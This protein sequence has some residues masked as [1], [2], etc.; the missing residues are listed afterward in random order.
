MDKKLLGK[1]PEGKD[2]YSYVIGTDGLRGTFMNYGAICLKLIKHF[3]D[4]E[5]KDVDIMLGFENLSDYFE[6][7]PC[8]GSIVGRCANRTAGGEFTLDGKTYEL[9]KN[10][11]GINNLH[12]GPDVYNKRIWDV[13]EVTDTSIT[14]TLDSPDKD[15]GF[16]HA[17]HM[18]VKYTV[19]KKAMIID[20]SAKADGKTVWNPTF[21]GYFNLDE[22]ENI[23]GH[24]F[25]IHSDKITYANEKSIP[26]G[27][28]RDVAGT[29]FDFHEP[30]PFGRHI[31]DDYDELKYAGG[32]DHNFVLKNTFD[33]LSKEYSL[34]SGDGDPDELRVYEACTLYSACRKMKVFT[35]LPGIQIYT[36]NYIQNGVKGKYGETYNRRKGVAMESQYF[37]NAINIPEFDQPVI[38]EKKTYRHRT[39]YEISE[40]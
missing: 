16:P 40:R 14:F 17:L 18:E 8:F 21:H 24:E 23:L 1:S 2:I 7:D 37:P 34:K 30:M 10:D 29:P 5:I 35:D 31:E 27:T 25:S 33:I 39:V 36:G 32:Y 22:S 11:N 9:Q 6:N 12:S 3:N 19:T 28:F 4:T 26:D 20:Y 38:D 15:Q 13:K